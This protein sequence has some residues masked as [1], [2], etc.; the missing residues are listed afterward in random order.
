[1][2][3]AFHGPKESPRNDRSYPAPAFE[4]HDLIPSPVNDKGRATDAFCTLENLDSRCCEQEVDCG[5]GR[6][7]NALH[8]VEVGDLVFVGLGTEEELGE[9]LAKD[10]RLGEDCDQCR[11]KS[12]P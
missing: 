8:L 11:P 7:R 5:L 12:I 4:G 6:G 2:V 9:D 3:V 1:M 10:W